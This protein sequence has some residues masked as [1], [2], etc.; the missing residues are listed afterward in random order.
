MGQEGRRVKEV[1]CFTSKLNTEKAMPMNIKRGAVC[2][3]NMSC[4]L[5]V[6][7]RYK[8]LALVCHDLRGTSIDI[9]MN[10]LACI[11]NRATWN[12]VGW[13]GFYGG[14]AW[15][16]VVALA[17]SKAIYYL[18]CLMWGPNIIKSIES[19]SRFKSGSFCTIW[20]AKMSKLRRSITGR[21]TLESLFFVLPLFL[22]FFH[23]FTASPV[24]GWANPPTLQQSLLYPP[25]W[26]EWWHPTG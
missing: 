2:K 26:E 14:W 10:V 16:W 23:L 3:V 5:T 8:G 11:S 17:F 21:S 6:L 18:Q 9:P 15:D 20:T 12:A 4:L 22:A 13:V 24:T 25:G 19:D 7:T 1:L